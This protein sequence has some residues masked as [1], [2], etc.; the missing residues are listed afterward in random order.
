MYNSTVYS[1]YILHLQVFNAIVSVEYFWWISRDNW[2]RSIYSNQIFANV[3]FKTQAMS[4]T[5]RPW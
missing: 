1:N 3:Y 4:S 5:L 2:L